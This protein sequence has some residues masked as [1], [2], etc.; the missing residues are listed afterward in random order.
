MKM[1]I[2]RNYR[3]L[4]HQKKLFIIKLY[5]GVQLALLHLLSLLFELNSVF[6]SGGFEPEFE[7]PLCRCW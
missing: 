3:R 6:K 4:L 2:L 7:V 5:L 1:K